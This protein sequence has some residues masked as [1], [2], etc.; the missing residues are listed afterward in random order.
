MNMMIRGSVKGRVTS[1][2]YVQNQGSGF[3]LDVSFEEFKQHNVLKFS[4]QLTKDGK[5][6]GRIK[7]AD[8]ELGS[9]TGQIRLALDIENGSSQG[10]IEADSLVLTVEKDRPRQQ[11]TFLLD[12]A[13]ASD[14]STASSADG[15]VALVTIKPRRL[16]RAPVTLQFMKPKFAFMAHT[17]QAST[18]TAQTAQTSQTSPAKGE[19]IR[20]AGNSKKC[21]QTKE[22]NWNNGNAIHLWDCNAGPDRNKKW[23]YEPATGYIRS[24]ANQS[25]CIHKKVNNWNNGNVIHLWDCSAGSESNKSWT[26]DANSK[27]IKARSK[28]DMCIHKAE[29]GWNN[30]NVLHLWKCSA[31]GSENKT[32]NIPVAPIDLSGLVMT[33]VLMTPL[34]EPVNTDAEGPGD[35]VDLIQDLE[36]ANFKDKEFLG[37]RVWEDKNPA[38]GKYY[39]V[40]YYYSLDWDASKDD[41]HKYGM[42]IVYD[43]GPEGQDIGMGMRLRSS[44]SIAQEMFVKKILKARN[45][46]FEGSLTELKGTTTV[47]M[48][49]RLT[50]LFGIA[51]E[52][53][54]VEPPALNVVK[55]SW[56]TNSVSK[57]SLASALTSQMG[58]DGEVVVSN[59][60][61]EVPTPMLGHLA[62]GRTYGRIDWDRDGGW[63][64]K[65]FHPVILKYMYA[66]KV[67]NDLSIDSWDLDSARVPTGSRV[68]W[69]A[70]EVPTNLEKDYDYVWFEY[71]VESCDQCDRRAVQAIT[72]STSDPQKVT[73]SVNVM[74]PVSS[75]GL[76]AGLIKIR[77]RNLRPD[78]S[79]LEIVDI[80]VTDQSSFEQDLYV[81]PEQSEQQLAEYQILGVQASGQ[82][83]Q[84]NKWLPINDTVIYVGSHQVAE[85]HGASVSCQ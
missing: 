49:N 29:P 22:P 57:E 77:S 80:A 61:A 47:T 50:N 46:Q 10:L 17:N 8:H 40:P 72:G 16:N 4:A 12:K 24:A 73:L 31:G 84:T 11:Y 18:Q 27:L 32:W 65:T 33:G 67:G 51:E 58:I 79:E 6:V 39:Y 35:E 15:P 9:E 69:D 23:I 37:I 42:E 25:K 68:K 2:S 14:A 78:G 26:Y 70:S 52:D 5:T 44:H 54:V 20:S 55:I 36:N 7:V 43:T 41:K 59:S 45:S 81:L 64:N 76:A 60:G 13:W 38:S 3:L 85:L 56:L 83:L 71:D 1:V 34:G 21:F 62:T 66:I 53:I 74:T 19:L 30:G 28:T 48:A 63:E 75:C 82:M